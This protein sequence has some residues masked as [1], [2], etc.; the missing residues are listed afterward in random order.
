[1]SFR[2]RCR[3][4]PRRFCGCAGCTCAGAGSLAGRVVIPLVQAQ[5]LATVSVSGRGITIASIICARSLVS[6][7][8]APAIT[9]PSGPPSCSTM[10][11]FLVPILALSVGLGLSR[12]PRNGSYPSPRRRPATPRRRPQAHR[13]QRPDTP[14]SPPTHR[15]RQSVETSRE[16]WSS[17]QALGHLVPLATRAQTVD[18]PVQHET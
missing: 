10:T 9:A 5:V 18:D 2:P 6:W 15:P 17:H 3:A 7:T 13:T 12:R 4:S 14:R 1:M 8:L 16:R 11:L